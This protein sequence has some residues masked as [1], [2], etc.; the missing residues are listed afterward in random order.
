MKDN[1]LRG[2]VLAKY[3]DRRRE[4][5]IDLQPDDFGVP[6]SKLDILH[7]ESCVKSL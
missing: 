7:P 5:Y 1:E 2:I 4:Q 3:Y 6:I